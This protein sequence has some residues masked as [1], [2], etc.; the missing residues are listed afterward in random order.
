MEL[1]ANDIRN[2]EFPSQM[3][4]Y[5]KEEVDSLLEEAAAALENAKQES[6]KLSKE[7]ESLSIQ[8]TSLKQF[9]DTIKGA[10][11]DARRNA[12]MTMANARTEADQLITKAKAES[13][14]ILGSRSDEVSKIESQ[15]AKLEHTKKSYLTKVRDM[16]QSHMAMIDEIL[17]E[18]PETTKQAKKPVEQ[19]KTAQANTEQS[20]SEQSQSDDTI[21]VLD[22]NE[23]DVRKRET[24]A[25]QPA[26]S[27][28]IIT[29]E[30]HAADPAIVKMISKSDV[31]DADV[32]SAVKHLQA[33]P[34]KTASEE[35]A[36]APNI[37]GAVTTDKLATDVPSE[38]IPSKPVAKTDASVAETAKPTAKPPEDIA[39]ALDDVVKSFE[40][41]MDEASG[42]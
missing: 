29:E 14:S 8:F 37:S 32:A 26:K 21:T 23:V 9:E 10:A 30:A 4:G 31:S 1:T 25:T 5:D 19:P 35:T 34:P 20:K 36:A 13:E 22:S 33:I 24:I 11:I 7:V 40:E 15:I 39:A 38:F 3:R 12:D 18:I 41:K 42:N 27:Q 16:I 2:Y 6:L 17:E 28:T